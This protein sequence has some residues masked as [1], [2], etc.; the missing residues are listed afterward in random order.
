MTETR[1][2][3]KFIAEQ[4]LHQQIQCKFDQGQVKIILPE[5]KPMIEQPEKADNQ[6]AAEPEAETGPEAAEKSEKQKNE[7]NSSESSADLIAIE[8]EKEFH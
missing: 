2:L 4:G 6:V 8:T 1:S 5:M 3:P 7:D